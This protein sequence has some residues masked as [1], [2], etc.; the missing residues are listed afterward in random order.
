MLWLLQVNDLLAAAVAAA[1]VVVSLRFWRR[2]GLERLKDEESLWGREVVVVMVM[3]G[4]NFREEEMAL[5]ATE[6]EEVAIVGG[7]LGSSF[8]A[9]VT[10]K[11][12]QSKH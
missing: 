2:K 8:F 1:V 10:R 12:V 5:R 7:T 6:V 4:C 11:K 9:F 3:V